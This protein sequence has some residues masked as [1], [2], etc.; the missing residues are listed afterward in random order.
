MR[1]GLPEL[2]M[3]FIARGR[4]LL[5]LGSLRGALCPL[6]GGAAAARV[7]RGSKAPARP[8]FARYS[9]TPSRP[10]ALLRLLQVD[11]PTSTT[12]DLSNI[13]NHR[14][15]WLGPLPY[16]RES[17]LGQTTVEGEQGQGSRTPILDALHRDCSRQRLRPDPDRF[18]HLLSQTSASSL[19]G[20]T[21]GEGDAAAAARACMAHAA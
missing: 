14:N 9:R 19:S 17:P 3:P 2:E 16:D 11:V 5:P 15:P 10:R 8:F 4:R 7:H 20:A 12:V 1:T 6:A 13:P 21:W 18:G